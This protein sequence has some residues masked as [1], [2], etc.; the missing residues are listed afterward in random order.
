[1]STIQ[2]T[3]LITT[4]W[5]LPW[6]IAYAWHLNRELGSVWSVKSQPSVSMA[7][8]CC[9]WY[10][11]SVAYRRYDLLLS[12]LSDSTSLFTRQ[13]IECLKSL[14]HLTMGSVYNLWRLGSFTRDI[15]LFAAGPNGHWHVFANYGSDQ[16][17]LCFTILVSLRLFVPLPR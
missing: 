14:R 9:L 11:V 16:L 7:E 13:T 2:F 15:C 1:M 10:F 3:N 6:R 12:Q 5:N 4:V 8:R 17:P